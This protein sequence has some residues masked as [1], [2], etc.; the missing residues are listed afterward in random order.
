MFLSLQPSPHVPVST[1]DDQSWCP[2]QPQT[3]PSLHKALLEVAP[4]SLALIALDLAVLDSPALQVVIHLRRVDGSCPLLILGRVL[5]NPVVDIVGESAAGLVDLGMGGICVVRPGFLKSLIPF[6]RISHTLGL[7]VTGEPAARKASGLLLS[8]E[9]WSSSLYQRRK[10]SG[11][12]LYGPCSHHK[13][14]SHGVV[15]VDYQR[16]VR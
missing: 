2:P 6:C 14:N 4:E 10:V 9:L 3:S 12:P 8:P 1:S 13:N 16:L 15:C 11:F 7:W 5:A